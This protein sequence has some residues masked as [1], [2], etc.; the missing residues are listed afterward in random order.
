[1]V[2]ITEQKFGV[3]S[4]FIGERED[5]PTLKIPNVYHPSSPG[6]FLQYGMVRTMPGCNGGAFID[7]NHVKV[8]VPDGNPVIHHERHVS[9][10]GVEYVFQYTKA[11]VYLWDQ[12]TRT[13]TTMFTTSADCTLWDSVSL[14]GKV[15]ST[16]G[17]DLVQVW[18][19]TTPGTVFAAF[20]T[21]GGIDIDGVGGLLTRAKYLAAYEGNLVLGALTEGG[22]FFGRRIRISTNNDI[23]D[24]NVNGTG[25]TFVKDLNE[26]SDLIKGFGN[27]TF[28]ESRI[29]VVFKEESVYR[30]WLVQSLSVYNIKKT[31]GEVGLQ[32]TH[33]VINDQDGNLYY[34][35]DDFTIRK[36]LFGVV[37]QAKAVTI[38]AMNVTV[39]EDVEAVFMRPYNQLWW[40]IP[41]T[42]GSS[43]L[44]AVIV[45]NLDY[46]VW[47]QYPFA[48]R[49]FG[50]WSQQESL[51]IDGLDVL[52][53][54]IDGL[55]AQLPSIDFIEGTVGFKLDLASDY[56]GFTY[57]AH[58]SE[59]DKGEP[60]TRSFIISVDLTNKRSLNFFKRVS[61]SFAY[62]AARSS[63]GTL[64]QSVKR[65]TEKNFNVLGEFSL[66]AN[67][68]FVGIHLPGDIRAKHFLYKVEG[69]ILFDFLGMFWTF[70]FDGEY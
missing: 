9:G 45:L 23:T 35:A 39:V 1:M 25:D 40:S 28:L 7:T 60:V 50:R 24:F 3:L 15:I 33:S 30:L 8:Q 53:T 37:S 67:S 59:T 36:F 43:E 16:N 19:E 41:S 38:R 12:S 5:V 56:S 48:I 70:E 2:R 55:D 52:S 32:A 18:S 64:T 4:D 69:T 44:D 17:I 66:E 54:T 31:E 57:V 29:L 14:D 42:A 34:L 26:G 61:R 20:D 46:N 22:A 13:Y 62:F 49:S 68:D 6:C 47:H 58:A 51:T 63:T 10:A 65:D 21:A 11:H 27:Y